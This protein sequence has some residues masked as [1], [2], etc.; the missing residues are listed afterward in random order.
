MTPFPSPSLSSNQFWIS[1]LPRLL[2]VSNSTEVTLPSELA[3]RWAKLRFARSTGT[4][5]P[6]GK[7]RPR[8]RANSEKETAPLRLRSIFKN[9]RGRRSTGAETRHSIGLSKPFPS[10]SRDWNNADS[11]ATMP[12]EAIGK[13]LAAEPTLREEAKRKRPNAKGRQRRV[14]GEE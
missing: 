2:L 9:G 11:F 8:A 5:A 4:E 3:S 13:G 14:M 6:E 12:A 10:V 7:R 1:K